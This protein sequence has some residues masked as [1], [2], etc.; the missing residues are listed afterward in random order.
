M[1]LDINEIMKI[2]PHRYPFLL[3]D[4]IEELVPGER[5]V[6]LKNVTINEPFFAGHFP[7]APV[8]PGVLILEAIA[9]VGAVLVLKD[10]PDRNHKL[11]YFVAIESAKFRRPVLPGDQLRIEVT[12]ESMRSKF[13]K[14]RGE[15]SV[16]GKLAAETQVTYAVV[17]REEAQDRP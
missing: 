11:V 6:G 4:R 12:V 5:V 15:A 17:D 14:M 9:Q 16:D 7:Q 10:M 3:V 8:M 2:I 1:R 13:G